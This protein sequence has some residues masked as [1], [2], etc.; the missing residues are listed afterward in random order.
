MPFLYSC[1][2]V[3]REM[4][5]V[6]KTI[7]ASAEEG[8]IEELADLLWVSLFSFCYQE[9]RVRRSVFQGHRKQGNKSEHVGL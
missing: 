4:T 8:V 5:S 1:Q 3:K 6:A 2:E 7:D 9:K